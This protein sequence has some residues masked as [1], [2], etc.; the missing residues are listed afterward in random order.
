MEGFSNR[1]ILSSVPDCAIGLVCLQRDAGDSGEVP[2][3]TGDA[4]ALGTGGEDYCVLRPSDTYLSSVYD[5][6]EESNEGTF[7]IPLCSGD[8]DF[9]TYN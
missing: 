8:C 4:N 9:G 7:P 6:F 5:H 3:C 2:S 1:F